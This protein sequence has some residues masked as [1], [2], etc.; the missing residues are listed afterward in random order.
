MAKKTPGLRRIATFIVDKRLLV[1]IL[2][3]A[4]L[5]A[6]F[7]TAGLTVVEDDLYR[8]LPDETETRRALD[9]MG[10]EFYTY[11]TAKV[12]VDNV[13]L[14]EAFNI[15]AKLREGAGIKSVSF[16]F[17]KDHYRGNAA[18]FDV[19]FKGEATD[20]ISNTGLQYVKS[21]L[22]GYDESYV[23]TEVGRDYTKTIVK[24]MAIVGSIVVL[25]VIGMLL[26]TSRSYA[27]V[28]I[29]LVT[30]AAAA[31]I[32]VGTNFIFSCISYISNAITLVLQL[33]LAI[34]YAVILCNRY[35]EEHQSKPPREAMIAALTKAIPEISASSLTTIGGLVAMSFMQ[36][37]LGA[38]LAMVLIKSIVI[39]MLTVFLFM[40]GLVVFFAKAIDKTRHRSFVPKVS[41]LGNFAWKT[42]KVVPALLLVVMIFS[43]YFAFHVDY[44]YDYESL[45]PIKMN[46]RQEARAKIVDTFGNSNMMALV[47]PSGAYD[48]E[49]ELLEQLE[50]NPHVI[51]TLGLANI[52][53][54][55][56][57]RLGDM[58]SID[59]FS[60]LAGLDAMS[61]TALFALYAAHNSQYEITEDYEVPLVDMFLFLYDVAESGQLDLDEEQLDMIE[62]YYDQLSD[63][64]LQLKGKTY[65]RM[66]IYSDYPVQSDE[67]YALI[68]QIH[69]I[70]GEYY[71]DEVFVAGN[72]TSSRD[73][74]N[75]FKTD[76]ILN[77]VLSALFVIIVIIFTF[78]SFGLSVLLIMII[79][80]SIW[81]NFSVPYFSGEKVFFLSYLIV[82]AIQMGAN[83]D[84][85][86]VVSN[87]YITLRDQ[88]CSKH[89]SITAAING[90]L[91]T[92]L[93]S[94]S[95]LAVAGL[96]IGLLVSESASSNIGISLGR[97]TLI[98]LVL[99]LF[100]LPQVLLMGDKFIRKTTFKKLQFSVPTRFSDDFEALGRSALDGSAKAKNKDSGK[101]KPANQKGG[102]KSK[103]ANQKGGGKGNSAQAKN[104]KS[105]ANTKKKNK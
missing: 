53:V 28:P 43:C 83:I 47:V 73:L 39:S 95:I 20:D 48:V 33:A 36:F 13:S 59:Q 72:T 105:N 82:G 23:S 14:D 79:Q 104:G 84:Y 26:L 99:V 5:L 96:L 41:R 65:S 2:F 102:G 51:S 75:S 27:E 92:L 57:Y 55:E 80:S 8:F 38:D 45:Y 37:G 11:G 94:G 56:G 46:E 63:A 9:A 60:E 101:G 66:L 50:E 40:P 7:F 77:T 103:P 76:S 85:A 58:I 10:S 19:T 69:E 90:A 34:D 32:Q 35:A 91:P 25:I 18:L 100:V 81:I 15:A 22:H 4:A 49:A 21:V 42:R 67:S 3:V 97:G 17:D 64:K 93:T 44:G 78:R 98:S 54:A 30:F 1:L 71:G 89:E 68:D 16:S 86:I 87:R 61:S 52:D 31:I 88:H 6:S 74:D 12:M 24:N 70:A 62:G 29:L